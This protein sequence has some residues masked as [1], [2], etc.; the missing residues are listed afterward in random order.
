MK[1]ARPSG[2]VVG[3][4]VQFAGGSWIVRE[5]T[6]AAVVL[7]DVAGA[8]AEVAVSKLLADPGFMVVGGN[9]AGRAP[10]PARGALES[11]PS[12][13]AEQARRCESHVTEVLRGIPAGARST[14]TG[15]NTPVLPRSG[16]LG[17]PPRPLRRAPN[18]GSQPPRRRLDHRDLDASEQPAG[19][20]W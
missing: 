7:V 2:V 15:V 12:E 19:A 14:P 11:L 1:T 13:T 17:G 16:S 20:V 18:L 8:E 9:A 4:H 6:G 3:D 10:V 5:L